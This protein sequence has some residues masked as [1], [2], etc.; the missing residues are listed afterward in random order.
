MDNDEDDLMSVYKV[1]VLAFTIIGLVAATVLI[2]IIIWWGIERVFNLQTP[3]EFRSEVTERSIVYAWEAPRIHPQTLGSLI[4]NPL[5]DCL[6]REESSGD[7]NAYNPKDVD[8][9]P[10]Y[11][12]LQFDSGTFDDYCVKKYK[13]ENDLW[14]PDIQI[15][16]CENML[17]DG[18]GGHWGTYNRCKLLK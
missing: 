8:G 15:E 12:L 17:R 5:I 7:P 13:L 16:C 6:I 3:K 18:Y 10:K 2:L 1:M 11:G 14:N 4:G 9:R